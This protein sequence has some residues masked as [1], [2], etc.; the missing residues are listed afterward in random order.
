[1]TTEKALK[2]LVRAR[3][4]RTGE[5]YTAARLAFQYPWR[6]LHMLNNELEG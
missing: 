5:Q 1:M 4:R 3:M 2:R 6:Q